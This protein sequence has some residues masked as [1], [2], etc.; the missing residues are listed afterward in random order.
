M[1]NLQRLQSSLSAYSCGSSSWEGSNQRFLPLALYIVPLS[2]GFLEIYSFPEA[3]FIATVHPKDMI[4][5]MQTICQEARKRR[6]EDEAR[7]A[8]AAGLNLS[9]TLNL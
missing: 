9:I 6:E 7:R 3:D 4:P 8:P 1:N 5:V 2:S